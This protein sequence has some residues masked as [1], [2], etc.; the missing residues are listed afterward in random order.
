MVK[1]VLISIFFYINLKASDIYSNLSLK[2]AYIDNHSLFSYAEGYLELEHETQYFDLNIIGRGYYGLTDKEYRDTW[3]ERF[4]ISRKLDNL[5]FSLGKQ[6]LNWGESDYFRVVNILNPVDLRDYYLS[7]LNNPQSVT[8]SLWSLKLDYVGIENFGV[9][10]I[11]IPDFEM[12]N[13]P[14][15]YTGFSNKNI[16]YFKSLDTIK[17]DSL[18][19]KDSSFALKLDTSL[20]DNDIAL[21]YYHGWNSSPIQI[22]KKEKKIFRRDMIG[23]SIS[24]E[25]NYFVIRAESALYL[26]DA[27][28]TS[29]NYKKLNIVKSLIGIDWVNQDLS[30]STQYLNTHSEVEN[31]HEISLYIEEKFYN[32]NLVLSNISLHNFTTGVGLD[33]FKFKY[34]YTENINFYLGYDVFWGDEGVLSNYSSQNRLFFNLEFFIN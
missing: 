18:N 26:N 27:I 23:A 5:S 11:F 3:F 21:Y 19:L 14:D 7:Y 16:E 8:K 4:L 2:N 12:D 30:I 20:Y 33:E 22:S 1:L 32:N 34:R 29:N 13:L 31:M 9:N 17:P 25:I 24:R 6:V 10:F 15:V 28:Q